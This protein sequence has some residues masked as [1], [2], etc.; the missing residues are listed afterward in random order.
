VAQRPQQLQRDRQHVGIVLDHQDAQLACRCRHAGGSGAVGELGAPLRDPVE[1][2][3][4]ELRIPRRVGEGMVGAFQHPHLQRA[5]L[6]EGR[7][8]VLDHGAR[9]RVVAA[10]PDQQHIAPEGG[11]GGQR[12][13]VLGAQAQQA[14]G[15]QVFLVEL[16]LGRRPAVVAVERRRAQREPAHRAQGTRERGEVAAIADRHHADGVG[17]DLGLAGQRV[18]RR[19]HILEVVLARHRGP[20]G[21]RPSLVRHVD[22]PAGPALRTEV[23]RQRAVAL[24]VV[25][26]P[27]GH[28]QRARLAGGGRRGRA[29]HGPGLL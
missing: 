7:G 16:L 10:R 17:V 6:R 18:V 20:L 13:V 14:V 28:Q 21:R 15:R 9:H 2:A 4:P 27:P 3:K 24:A 29:V 23:A 22:Q 5:R 11:A 25:V 1:Q 26:V 12:A 19:Q 8:V